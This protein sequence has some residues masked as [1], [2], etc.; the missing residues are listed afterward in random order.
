MTVFLDWRFLKE[1]KRSKNLAGLSLFALICRELRRG[2]LHKQAFTTQKPFATDAADV[3]V[4]TRIICKD[5]LAER[6]V[7]VI[8]IQDMLW[9]ACTDAHMC[10]WSFCS[11]RNKYPSFYG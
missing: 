8:A 9:L 4:K 5:R 6:C 11:R 7:E 1:R 2:R 10:M 3:G